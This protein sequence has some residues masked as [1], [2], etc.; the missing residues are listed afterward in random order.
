[1][2]ACPVGYKQ[3]IFRGSKKRT[4]FRLNPIQQLF[5]AIRR[6]KSLCDAEG[7]TLGDINDREPFD[8]GAM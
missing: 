8:L 7:L 3:T 5:P 1:M 4:W 2:C 6:V